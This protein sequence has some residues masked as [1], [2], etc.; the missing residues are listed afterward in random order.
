VPDTSLVF[1]ILAKDKTK[2][3]FDGMKA[4]AVAAGA[5]VGLALAAGA[6][7][8]LEQSKITGTL[9]AQLGATQPQAAALGKAA[10]AVY[11]QGWGED[12][13]Q[14]A[15]AIKSAAQNG[16]VALDQIGSQASQNTIKSLLQVS[17]VV[18]DETDR[19]SAAVSTMLRTG[20][21]KSAQEAFDIITR[22]TQNGVNKS[23]DL[24]DTLEEYSTLFRSLG[25]N[26]SQSMGLLSQAIKGGARNADQAADAIKELGIR[27]IDGSKTSRAAYKALGLDADAM[28]AKIAKGGPSAAAGM[29]TILDRLRAIKDPVKQ[30][31]AG[32]GLLGTKWE[33]MRDAVLSM[34]LTSASKQMDGL[35]GATDRAGKAMETPAQRVDKLKRSIQQGLVDALAKAAPKIESTF[36]WLQ[37]N[38]GWVLPL[39]AGLTALAGV[40]YAISTA[41]KVWSA[42]QVVLNLALWTSPITWIVLGIIALVAVIVLI[43]TKTTWFQTIWKAVW[44]AIKWWYSTVLGFLVSAFKLWWAT[45]SGFWLGIGRFFKK[46]WDGIVSGIKSAWKWITNTFDKVVSAIGGAKKRLTDKAKGMFDGLKS[47]FRSAINWMIGK[48]NG[49]HLTLGGGSVLG[50]KIPSVTL[51]TP[52]IPYLAKGGTALTS[53]AAIVGERGPELVTLRPGATVTPLTGSSAA[54]MG[55]T[56]RIELIL[57]SGGSKLDDMLVEILRAA[58]K[59]RGGNVQVALGRG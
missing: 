18:G 53:G 8:T 31:A 52:N 13:P 7:Q 21:A 3:T 9:A 26:G 59:A 28:I 55:G 37:R 56:Q 42:V 25:L 49:F 23:G 46:V 20:M 4:S 50:V 57:R 33:D 44:G 11:A 29:D 5:S 2:K 30:N 38:Q 16:F 14:V 19:V 34:D 54:R 47:A 41:M 45:F 6:M 48:W 51:N 15:A 39:V 32:V 10:G 43:A 24:I 22:A 17:A 40:I 1:N 36:G 35:G 58:I 27:A 12:M